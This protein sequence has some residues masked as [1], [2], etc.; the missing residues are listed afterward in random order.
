MAPTSAAVVGLGI[1][2]GD[3]AQHLVAAGVRVV[4]VD[5]LPGARAKAREIGV[6]TLVGPNELGE[7]DGPII[8][9]LPGPAV[10]RDVVMALAKLPGQRRVVETS[11]LALGDKLA[12]RDALQDAGHTL[13]DCPISGT[14]AQMQ[15]G[16]VVVYASGDADA[17]AAVEPLLQL[18]SRQVLSLGAFGNGTRMKLIANHLVAVH[19]VAAAEAVLLGMKAGFS[20]ETLLAAIAPGAGNSRMFELRGPVVA[21]RAYE[22][23]AMKLSLWE[24]DMQLIDDFARELQAATPLFDAVVPLYAQALAAGRGEQDTAAVAEVL[25]AAAAGTDADGGRED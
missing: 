6:T 4:G 20:I 5:P 11:T 17:L 25:R 10:A 7:H 9:S 18:F 2:G 15:R 23:A 22:P 24:K 16:D 19:N 12:L 13:V 8:L 1:M 3:N 21:E 14:G